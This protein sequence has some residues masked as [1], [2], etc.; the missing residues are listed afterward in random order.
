MRIMAIIT[1]NMPGHRQGI[2]LRLVNPLCG[3]Y[4]VM[5]GL[6]EFISDIFLRHIAI[7][8]ISTIAG[9]V[10][11]GHQPFSMAGRMRAMA[12]EAGIFGHA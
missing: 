6:E 7:V 5:R 10:T 2:F 1:A 8:A 3:L 11:I 12:A 4:R 9:L